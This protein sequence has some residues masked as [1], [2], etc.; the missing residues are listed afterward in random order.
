MKIEIQRFQPLD[1]NLAAAWLQHPQLPK[2]RRRRKIY[3]F[4]ATIDG[5]P[6]RLPDGTFQWKTKGSLV[7][8][9]GRY[10]FFTYRTQF[11]NLPNQPYDQRHAETRHSV[12]NNYRVIDELVSANRLVISKTEVDEDNFLTIT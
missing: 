12:W 2:P 11:E 6:I 9:L 8:A 7:T 4:R 1:A 5:H 3:R 10:I